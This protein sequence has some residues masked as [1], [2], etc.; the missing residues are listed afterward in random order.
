[1]GVACARDIENGARD[2]REVV[3]VA[4]LVDERAPETAARDDDVGNVEAILDLAGG[5][6]D[7]LRIGALFEVA[8]QEDLGL[9]DIGV[10]EPAAAEVLRGRVAMRIDEGLGFFV[11]G[12]LDDR[13]SEAFREK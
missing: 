10:D 7:E 4:E 1:K 13:A 9:G 2:G 8:A 3:N 5:R 11:F 12:E 6:C